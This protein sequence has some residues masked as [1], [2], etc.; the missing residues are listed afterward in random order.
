MHWQHH[1]EGLA[2]VARLA[3]R[4]DPE[5]PE[6]GGGGGPLGHWRAWRRDPVDLVERAA[7]LGDAARFRLTYEP[8]HFFN[9]AGAFE[10]ILVEEA[11]K[12]ERAPFSGAVL[13][14]YIGRTMLNTNAEEWAEHRQM[15]QP[16]FHPRMVERAVDAFATE[17]AITFDDWRRYAR[18]G[19]T[20]D[21]A[22]EGMSLTARLSARAFLGV[23]I[24][25]QE[26]R[27]LVDAIVLT[28]RWIF[29]RMSSL[30]PVTV[31]PD[32]QAGFA[33]I[34]AVVTKAI[35]TPPP[36]AG[37]PTYIERLRQDK[38]VDPQ[39]VRD[40]VILVLVAAP[41]NPSNT[42]AWGA[43]LLAR[44]RGWEERLRAEVR[45]AFGDAAPTVEVL[46]RMP[47]LDRITREVMRLYPGA[48]LL[49]RFTIDDTV[50]EGRRLPAGSMVLLS[51]LMLHRNP[52]YWDEPLVFD[53]DRFLPERSE[54]R[55]RSA[56]MPFGG[57]PRVCI[58][59]RIALLEVKLLL[60]LLVQRFRVHATT[61]ESLPLEG[62]FALRA[63][64]GVPVR[65]EEAP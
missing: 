18:E 65:L 41:E 26:A 6:L 46:D 59:A 36:S 17:A 35:A 19:T 22:R 20:I 10:R 15:A 8:M 37:P 31:P 14:T 23:D 42:F 21:L 61:G 45:E 51:P 12:F 24:D 57:G 11:Q 27:S 55:P 44:H 3:K 64:D 43:W 54:G 49:D 56:Y 7:A 62:L 29:R 1:A 39:R 63:R 32:V 2:R 60:A 53:P 28:Q 47:L 30:V 13:A 52:R 9:T 40:S 5:I 4:L 50:V 58:A 16:S 34:E 48:W 38:S 25:L 33:R